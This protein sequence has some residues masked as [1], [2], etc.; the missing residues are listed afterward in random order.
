MIGSLHCKRN[1]L[2]LGVIDM[3]EIWRSVKGFE[4]VYE[5]SSEGRIKSKKHVIVR[6]D[7]KKY[8]VKEKLLKPYVDKDGY[9]RVE[10]NHKGK[11]GKFYVHRLVGFLFIPNPEEKPQINHINCIKDD[12]R[13]ENLEWVTVQENRTHAIKNG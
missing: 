1:C 11:A 7:G 8:T 10:L 9:L 6:R 12:N 2:F 4:G 13:V 3:K 5:V